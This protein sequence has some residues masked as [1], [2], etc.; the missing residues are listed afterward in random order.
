MSSPHVAGLAALLKQQHPDWSPMAIKSAL[1]T[2]G[3]DVLDGP[4]TNPLLIF[5][6]GA[7]H[8][9]P[10]SAADPGLVYDSGFNDWL[11][12]HLRRPSPG[13][14]LHARV[15]AGDSRPEQPERGVHRHR[16]PGR[17]ADRDPQGDQ[18]QRQAADGNAAD[19]RADWHHRRWSARRR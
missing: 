10:N 2:T 5:R 17:H 16:R 3:Y 6:Q 7:G 14:G 4:N 13:R 9:N 18:R 8:V 12:L 19:H 15:A 1:M 11:R